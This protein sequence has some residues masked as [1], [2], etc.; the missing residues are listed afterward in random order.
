[1]QSGN[2]KKAR[3]KV[4]KYKESAEESVADGSA[5]GVQ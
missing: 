1:M 3:K 5:D 4:W 2:I